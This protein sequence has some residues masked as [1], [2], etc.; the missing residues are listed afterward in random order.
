MCLAFAVS[1]KISM[2]AWPTDMAMAEPHNP[3]CMA[4]TRFE[5]KKRNAWSA[6]GI[7]EVGWTKRTAMPRS[8]D[9]LWAIS[10]M[11]TIHH[12]HE[13][14]TG[15]SEKGERRKTT[16]NFLTTCGYQSPVTA[17]CQA[18][19]SLVATGCRAVFQAMPSFPTKASAFLLSAS[20]EGR[21]N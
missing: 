14:E 18:N 11:F 12:L 7:A 16:A 5:D 1:G 10:S 21:I 4:T 8:L 6:A 15:E 2:A 3:P 19:Q 20:L 13:A 9:T 17:G